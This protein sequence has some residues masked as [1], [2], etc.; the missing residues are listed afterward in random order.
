[1]NQIV[2]TFTRNLT[3]SPAFDKRNPSPS[4]NYGI[5][6]VEM[7]FLLMGPLGAVQFVLYTNWHLPHV[8]KEMMEK[9][10]DAIG[11][12]CS[13]PMPADLGYHSPKPMYKGQEEFDCDLLPGGKCYCDGSGLN[14]IPVF[15]ILVSEGEE[16]LWKKLE[17]YYHI[18]FGEG[19]AA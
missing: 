15:D 5:H 18:I 17:D 2:E 3:F 6:G 1:M 8:E 12:H 14:A 7:R 16:A 4:K 13:R 19:D 10:V 9:P 11:Y